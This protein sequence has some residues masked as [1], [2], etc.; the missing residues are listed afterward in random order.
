[1]YENSC[2]KKRVDAQAHLASP[3]GLG[4]QPCTN[5]FH[6]RKYMGWGRKKD[7]LLSSR[8]CMRPRGETEAQ[9]YL[10]LG[11]RHQCLKWGFCKW[12]FVC[13]LLPPLFRETGAI[14]F[15]KEPNYTMKIPDFCSKQ[16]IW[17][18]KPWNLL[19]PSKGATVHYIDHGP[20][21]WVELNCAC[22]RM[23][24]RDKSHLALSHTS[25][26]IN[27]GWCTCHYTWVEM[28]Q[29]PVKCGNVWEVKVM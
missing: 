29:L 3:H 28:I 16:E 1:M 14:A 13:S 6:G 26:L 23:K 4:E 7:H 20:N 9:R 17:P 25:P 27:W 5:G 18:A 15:C 24:E 11:T 19:L 22:H 2:T 21:Y 8:T 10:L 12:V